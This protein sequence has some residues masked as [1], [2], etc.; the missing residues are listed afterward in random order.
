MKFMFVL[1]A[2]IVLASARR[3]PPPPSPCGATEEVCGKFG[4]PSQ[5]CATYGLK[6][7]G[8][9]DYGQ[10]VASRSAAVTLVKAG[11]C[12]TV[13]RCAPNGTALAAG[14]G[15]GISHVTYCG[16]YED[17]D[18]V[19]TCGDVPSPG[20]EAPEEEEATTE[21]E[22]EAAE[23]QEDK[24]E[25]EAEVNTPAPTN[26]PANPQVEEEAG[27]VIVE[28]PEQEIVNPFVQPPPVLCQPRQPAQKQVVIRVKD[29]CKHNYNRMRKRLHRLSKQASRLLAKF[30]SEK[31]TGHADT[32]V[33]A[34]EKIF[35]PPKISIASNAASGAV[36]VT[37]K[38]SP[39]SKEKSEV[40]ENN[41]A[42]AAAKKDPVGAVKYGVNAL[43]EEPKVPVQIVERPL[44]VANQNV[45]RGHVIGR[46]VTEEG[47]PLDGDDEYYKNRC[48]ADHSELACNP[49]ARKKA[50][51]VY[52]ARANQ[53]LN[54]PA[55]K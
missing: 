22:K 28:Q 2:M 42:A 12:H 27:G 23:E 47:F 19:A 44:Q 40:V 24:E 35:A 14:S 13:Y 30:S 37:K 55:Y 41:A 10:T 43:G 32:C 31:W 8:K 50:L 34:K 29:H 20:A 53:A 39:A 38:A 18:C 7:I 26:P 51:N 49:A 54:Q 33:V 36:V 17:A 1:I 21:E 15:K 46:I 5:E 4:N 6:P 25:E 16:D 48:V 52:E 11:Q 45:A 3:A 9:D